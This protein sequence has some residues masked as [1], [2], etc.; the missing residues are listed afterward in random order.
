[1]TNCFVLIGGSATA[2]G[3]LVKKLGGTVLEYLFII[4]LT[5]LK[6]ASKLDAPMYSIVKVDD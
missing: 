1:M 5:F 2:A 6:A 4:E 3:Q